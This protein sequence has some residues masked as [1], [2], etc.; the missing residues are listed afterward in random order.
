MPL[1]DAGNVILV[2]M[3]GCGKSTLGRQLARRLRKRF[4]DS[5]LEIE[6][7]TGVS[8]PVIFEKEGESGFREREGKILAELAE[9]KDIVLATGGG[10]VLS[11][12]NRKLLRKAGEVVYLHAS[13]EVLFARTRAAKNRPLL[14]VADPEEKLRQLYQLRDP[15]YRET[16]HIVVESDH[17]RVSALLNRLLQSLDRH[18]Y[19]AQAKG[20]RP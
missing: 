1:R 8:I 13:V 3:M 15:I 7:R 9:L 20:T 10:A 17:H 2:G 12:A 4:I 11:E 5:D 16:A 14:D 6:E 18:P 19:R